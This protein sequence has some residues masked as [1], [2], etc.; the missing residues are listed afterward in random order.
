MTYTD[1][2]FPELDAILKEISVPKDKSAAAE[3]RAKKE[4]SKFERKQE[5]LPVKKTNDA[6]IKSKD[7]NKESSLSGKGQSCVTDFGD[8]S[9]MIAHTNDPKSFKQSKHGNT[10]HPMKVTS[11]FAANKDNFEM[12]NYLVSDSVGK[13]KN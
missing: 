10:V 6:N 2:W 7:E 12:S 13:I 3:E 5:M 9:E 4:I 11:S 8:K 1:I